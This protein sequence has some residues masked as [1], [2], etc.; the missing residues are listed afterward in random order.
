MRVIFLPKHQMKVALIGGRN[1]K[2]FHGA[3]TVTIVAT[4]VS[5]QLDTTDHITS[6]IMKGYIH[7]LLIAISWWIKQASEEAKL[8]TITICITHC[9][10]F[11]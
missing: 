2:Q 1:Y 5:V 9:G 8:E 3:L 6:I 4:H 7:V 10:A 11:P